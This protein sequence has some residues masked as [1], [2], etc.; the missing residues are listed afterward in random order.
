MAR[1]N[2]YYSMDCSPEFEISNHL[3]SSSQKCTTF[4]SS[5]NQILPDEIIQYQIIP[6]LDVE[7]MCCKF[8]LLSSHLYKLAEDN[9]LWRERFFNTLPSSQLEFFQNNPLYWK[10]CYNSKSTRNYFLSLSPTLHERIYPSLDAFSVNFKDLYRSTF[11][12]GRLEGNRLLNSGNY[13]RD[14]FSHHITYYYLIDI[15]QNLK[16]TNEEL[17]LVDKVFDQSVSPT[18]E[19]FRGRTRE[20][21]ALNDDETREYYGVFGIVIGI[22]FVMYQEWMSNDLRAHVIG[23][24]LTHRV[25][26]VSRHGDEIQRE[27][28]SVEL[29]THDSAFDY[30]Y[31]YNEKLTST[32]KN[33][34]DFELSKFV[35]GDES[36]YPQYLYLNQST[37]DK[38][39]Q[40]SKSQPVSLTIHGVWSDNK[41]RCGLFTSENI[42]WSTSVF[43]LATLGSKLHDVN[44]R[45]VYSVDNE[46]KIFSKLTA[47]KYWKMT[48]HIK[49]DATLSNFQS[50]EYNVSFDCDAYVRGEAAV[51]IHHSQSGPSYS[52][53]HHTHY[54]IVGN[55]VDSYFSFNLLNRGEHMFLAWCMFDDMKN[56]SKLKSEQA[57]RTKVIT[58]KEA[59]IT[60]EKVLS[61]ERRKMVLSSDKCGMFPTMDQFKLSG[62]LVD[63]DGVKGYV[64]L[65]PRIHLKQQ[66]Q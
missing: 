54:Q 16:L 60:P 45:R 27:G 23:R 66:Q 1:V 18:I 43:D 20:K 61:E 21:G 62:I 28:A 35:N 12:E 14:Q 63:R 36:S 7:T 5:T 58:P 50:T 2:D 32:P 29:R 11:V 49:I 33:N 22:Y 25:K 26:E 53:Q 64:E 48:T 24:K 42:D 13:K 59:P 9:L 34:D 65:E 31:F 37:E 47:F 57:I 44:Y 10:Q 41:E 6:F 17:R 38:W 15:A 55:A 56:E 3:N 40:R 4:H 30:K 52:H 39:D 51:A 46:V 8:S 19:F